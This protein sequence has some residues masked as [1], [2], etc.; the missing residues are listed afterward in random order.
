MEDITTQV[1]IEIRDEVRR[2]NQRLDGTNERLDA[3][4]ERLDATVERLDATVERLDATVERL[5]RV[6]RRQVEAEV[7]ISTELV[8]VAGAIREMKDVFLEDRRLAAQVSDHERRIQVL[9]TRGP[10]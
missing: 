10:V 5:D 3:T 1:L 2:T 9:E 4:V 8:A 6:E 7:R